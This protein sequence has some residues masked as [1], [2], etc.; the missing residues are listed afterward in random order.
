MKPSICLSNHRHTIM[1][2]FEL[3]ALIALAMAAGACNKEKEF[4]STPEDAVIPAEPGKIVFTAQA[5]TK[6]AIDANDEVV[7]WVEGDEV[8]FSWDGGSTTAT[9]ASSGASTTFTIDAPDDATEIYAIYPAS[10]GGSVNNGKV[11]VHY[12]GSRADGSFAANDI[13]V[14]RAV[15]NGDAWETSLAFKNAACLLKIGVTSSE[16]VKIKVQA[17]GDEE[18]A[19]AFEVSMD[20]SGNP[21]VGD[22]VGTTS[23]SSSMTVSGPGNYYIPIKPGV[24]LTEGFR[25]NRITDETDPDNPVQ[26]TPFYYNASFTTGRGKIIKLNDIDSHAG[27]YY[28]TPGGAGTG[29]GQSWNNAMDAATFKAFIE[30]NEGNNY[31]ILRGAVFHLSAAEFTFGTYLKPA[32]SGHGE[33][34]FTIEGTRDGSSITTFVGGTGADAGMLEPGQ[35]T[36]LTVRNVK[37]TGT[38]GNSNRAAIRVNNTS[39]ILTLDNCIFHNN[40]TSG[41]SGA[42]NIIKGNSVVITDCEFTSNSSSTGGASIHAENITLSVS[43]CTFSNNTGKGNVLH[44]TNT[45]GVVAMEDCEISGGDN[46][47]VFGVNAN[48]ISFERVNFHDNHTSVKESAGAVLLTGAGTY[49]FTDCNFI[50][51]YSSHEAGAVAIRS[52]DIQASFIGGK[53]QGNHADGEDAENGKYSAGAAIYAIGT[54]VAFDCTNVLFKKNYNY[55]GTDNLSGGIIKVQQDGGTARFNGC[56][57]DG[58]YTNRNTGDNKPCSAIVTCRVGGVNYYF[59]ACEFKENTSGTG[60]SGT[61]RGGLRGTVFAT[62]AASTFAF[63]NCSFHDNYGGRNTDDITWIGMDNENSTLILANTTIVG[64]NTKPDGTVKN[65]WGVI[66]FQNSGN[67]Y[68][69]NSILCS[70]DADSSPGNCFWV[71]DAIEINGTTIANGAKLPV[72]CYYCKT[73]KEGDNRTDWGADTGSGHD[74]YASSASFGGWSAPWTWNGTLTGT[75][76][77]MKA[78][79]ADVNTEIQTADADFYAWLNSI[80]ALGKDINGNSRGAT[81][82]PGC[83]QN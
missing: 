67:F 73:S 65:N 15:K 22:A 48:T 27:H 26:L 52:G 23:S 2:K 8:K 7:S 58:N 19:G 39:V 79:T 11:T 82:W 55:V 1:K 70:N 25:V 17:V 81:S 49:T 29:S 14:A 61:T 63:N 47:A 45:N 10:A 43:G 76:S 83:Y 36:N 5:P 72:Y 34:A 18:I 74:Y 69:L 28:V 3:F 35:S 57:F 32:F 64:D 37:F 66:K 75:N 4:E 80:G 30:N 71:N 41:Q 50:D 44:V 51:N 54:G 78:A 38:D 31:F 12:S 6:T 21:V 24:T 16:I 77:N 56:V 46:C 13:C 53:F 20:D 40:K 33:V 68:L 42:I 60:N 9:A 59:N 62:L